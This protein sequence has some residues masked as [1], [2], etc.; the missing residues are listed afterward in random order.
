MMEILSSR[1][2]FRSIYIVVSTKGPLARLDLSLWVTIICHMSEVAVF[3]TK[4]AIRISLLVN[5]LADGYKRKILL[6]KNIFEK[7]SNA[8]HLAF[9]WNGFQNDGSIWNISTSKLILAYNPSP[10]ASL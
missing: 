5:G 2:L 7:M 3:C 1:P 10:W 9:A 8:C 4:I 6:S